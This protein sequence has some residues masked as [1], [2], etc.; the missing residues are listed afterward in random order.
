MSNKE[1]AFA[2]EQKIYRK[3][4]NRLIIEGVCFCLFVFLTI[5]F[6]TLREVTKEI[7]DSYI[8]IEVIRYNETY[9]LLGA[10]FSG[11]IF[12]SLTVIFCD[13]FGGRFKT[14]RILDDYLTIYD[15]IFNAYIYINGILKEK[16]AFARLNPY[17]DFKLENG[18][19]VHIVFTRFGVDVSYSENLYT[20][21]L[22]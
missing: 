18:M 11:M 16:I 7:D 14:I 22:L 20:I 13:L 6:F 12:L 5:L 1:L 2:L 4:R 9:T 19:Y 21:D 3:K 17:Y 15:A 8:H 10:I